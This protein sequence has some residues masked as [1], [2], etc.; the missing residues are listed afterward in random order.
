MTRRLHRKLLPEDRWCRWCEAYTGYLLSHAGR[1]LVLRCRNRE[2]RYRWTRIK[3][4]P[5]VR[6]KINQSRGVR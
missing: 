1:S 3:H 6:T 4:L 2:C 5:A